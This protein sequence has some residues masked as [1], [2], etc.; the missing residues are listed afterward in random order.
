M[1]LALEIEVSSGPASGAVDN[2][3]PLQRVSET[4][5]LLQIV[6]S[7]IFQFA[8]GVILEELNR[9]CPAGEFPSCGFAAAFAD[10]D[11]LRPSRLCPRAAHAYETA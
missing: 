7:P 8:Q 11:K 1:L 2:R 5:K 9:R 3:V 6:V 10:F 4:A